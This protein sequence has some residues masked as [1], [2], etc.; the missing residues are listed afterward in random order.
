MLPPQR[1]RPRR[2][3]MMTRG[4]EID[5]S[6][7]E[8]ASSARAQSRSRARR[9]LSR[10]RELGASSVEH[11]GAHEER[12]ERAPVRGRVL[13]EDAVA[14]ALFGVVLERIEGAR[15]QGGQGSRA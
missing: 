2:R 8:V 1:R 3:F 4:A 7:V 12:R 11:D 15:A 5:A 6:S 14:R 9:E 10:G 13:E